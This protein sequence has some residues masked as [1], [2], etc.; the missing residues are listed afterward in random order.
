MSPRV[1]IGMP[2]HN[3]E[4]YVAE[5][6]GSILS[7]TF[8]D[9]EL[10]ISDNGSTDA[11]EQICR[12]LA[13]ADGRIRYHR[14]E[15][16]RGAAWNF[17]RVAQ[18]ACGELFKWAAHD[19]LCAPGLIRRCVDVLDTDRDVILCYTR[20][21][22]IDKDGRVIGDHEDQMTADGP[23]AHQRF[24]A[25]LRDRMCYAVFGVV[26]R[27]VLMQTPLFGPYAH[28]DGVL[29]ARLAL[30][31]RFHQTDD[32]LFLSRRHPGQSAGMMR[33]KYMYTV[34]FDPTR[35]RQI[36]LPNWRINLEYAR[37][38]RAAPISAVDKLRCHMLVAR[39][40]VS[41][42]RRLLRDVGMASR[43]IWR[44]LWGRPEPKHAAV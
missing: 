32:Y 13:A 2:V 37:S 20:V 25:I 43:L 6:I 41:D 22:M 5:A 16:N 12:D 38:V 33:D 39:E 18:L 7:Q 26:R 24:A 29:L 15:T 27:D 4:P 36:V 8:E 40:F 30:R 10:V 1:S 11:T 23:Q 31:G 35:S 17:N 19:D 42:R 14:C 34:W 44:R 28:A 9:F 3:G 21:R